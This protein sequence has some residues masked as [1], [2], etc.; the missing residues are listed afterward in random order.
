MQVNSTQLALKVVAG[1]RFIIQSSGYLSKALEM[2]GQ[3]LIELCYCSIYEQCWV[4][5]RNNQP[6]EVAQCEIATDQRFVQ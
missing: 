2:D 6:K 4:V 1:D 3:V 5:D